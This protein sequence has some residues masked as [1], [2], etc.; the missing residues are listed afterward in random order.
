[1]VERNHWTSRQQL[2]FP[3]YFQASWK[4][5]NDFQLN[6]EAWQWALNEALPGLHLV[7]FVVESLDASNLAQLVA[8][9]TID[10]F[11]ALYGSQL[12]RQQESAPESCE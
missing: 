7:D 9:G 5:D 12:D 6:H 4:G 3:Y 11:L 2:Q 1:M 10:S 8:L